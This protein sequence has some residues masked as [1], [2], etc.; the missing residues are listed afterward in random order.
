MF[1]SIHHLPRRHLALAFACA[2]A[3][4]LASTAA[5]VP[6]T[7]TTFNVPFALTVSGL[8]PFDNTITG[9]QNG[10]ARTFTDTDGNVTQIVSN[11][12]EQDTFSANGRQLVGDPFRNVG[13]VLF[14]KSGNVTHVYETGVIER[15][16][17]P[18][19][20]VFLSA[21]IVDFLAHPNSPILITPD[22]GHSGNLDAF[23]AALAP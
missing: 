1:D 17:L 20:S 16:P 12:V 19:G 7:T 5:A 13:R 23:C 10:T 14:D 3:L 11:F 9:T 15:V 21:G 8:C 22:R 18:D 4:G 6:P 2:G